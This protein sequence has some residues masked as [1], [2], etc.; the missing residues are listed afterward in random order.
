[1]PIYEFLCIRCNNVDEKISKFGE[2][3]SELVCPSC[4]YKGLVRK[5]S[6]FS[7]PTVPG[8]SGANCGPC[9]KGSCST[10]K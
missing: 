9:S 5:L 7:A 6:T 8:G 10:C 3:G 1:M 2:D 4:N